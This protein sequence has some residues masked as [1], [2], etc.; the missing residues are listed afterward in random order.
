[1][2][3]WRRIVRGFVV[4]KRVSVTA[5]YTC[6]TA[7]LCCPLKTGVNS[8]LKPRVIALQSA[9]PLIIASLQWLEVWEFQKPCRVVLKAIRRDW[10][11]SAVK[12]GFQ[13]LN[14]FQA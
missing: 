11:A 5:R 6:T 9:K 3:L 1:M 13:P 8:R 14:S 2:G 7:L 10:K 12:F 4:K